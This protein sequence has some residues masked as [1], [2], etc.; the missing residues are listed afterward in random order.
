MVDLHSRLQLATTMAVS[1]EDILQAKDPEI[2]D[3]DDW[4]VYTLRK[5]NVLSKETGELVSLLVAHNDRPVI[6]LG[7]LEAVDSD[8][9]GNS[10][11]IFSK[12]EEA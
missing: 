4:P 6:V 11:K 2:K 9:I 12:T 3:S 8:L 5:T 10:E 1:E 7:T